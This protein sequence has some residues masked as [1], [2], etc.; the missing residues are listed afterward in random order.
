MSDIKKQLII[1]ATLDSAALKKEVAALKREL[2]MGFSLSSQDT[3]SIKSEFKNIARSFS[4]ELKKAMQ[5]FDPASG[6]SRAAR[7]RTPAFGASEDKTLARQEEREMAKQERLADRSRQKE[8]REKQKISEQSKKFNQ[9]S[10]DHHDRQLAE[11][12]K[13]KMKSVELEKREQEKLAKLKQKEEKTL[14]TIKERDRKKDL[15]QNLKNFETLR[16]RRLAEQVENSRADR[17]FVATAGRSVGMSPE[18]ARGFARGLPGALGAASAGF[19]GGTAAAAG[20]FGVVDKF[21]EA[22]MLSLERR[23]RFAQDIEEGRFLEGEVREK[24]RE[25]SFWDKGTGTAAGAGAGALGG[26]A[27]GAAV[28]SIVPVL[29]TAIGAAIGGLAGAA[30]GGA[31]GFFKGQRLRQEAGEEEVQKAAFGIR[32]FDSAKGLNPRMLQS[33]ATGASV[34]DI[35]G[36]VA[37]GSQF[38]FGAEQSLSQFQETQAALG[39]RAGLVT[40]FQRLQRGFGVG[41]GESATLEETL[42]GLGTSGGAKDGTRVGKIFEKA[43]SAGMDKAKLPALSQALKSTIGAVAGLSRANEE[44]VTSRLIATAQAL[45]RGEVT[46]QTIGQAATLQQQIA[47]EAKSIQGV[48]GGANIMNTMDALK[49]AGIETDLQTA[50]KLSTLAPEQVAEFAPQLLKNATQE[51]L[52]K[53]IP[54]QSAGQT[55]GT[56]GLFEKAFGSREDALFAET[57]TRGGDYAGQTARAT[58][59][60]AAIKGPM[61][62]PTTFQ[63]VQADRTMMTESG[64]LARAEAELDVTKFQA[65]FNLFEEGIRG[66]S[67]GLNKFNEQLEASIKSLQSLI[68]SGASYGV[69][70]T[71][72]GN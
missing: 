22:R 14:S 47:Q 12:V 46:E 59:I 61:L 10:W 38:G 24:G 40:D 28:G 34:E 43:V 4:E 21:R 3:Q 54:A 36:A 63:D 15:D 37:R 58:A 20:T 29:G 1:K 66:A 27:A 52:D 56:L 23:Q 51:Q 2:K 18:G 48:A 71:K 6:T 65:G 8:I 68:E 49:E 30:G 33:I 57:L 42:T 62:E 9:Q 53:F 44:Q 50:I 39:S 32:A 41:V 45:G 26:M 19:A 7:R 72:G 69:T 31:F 35:T 60:D 16:Q 25:T 13:G 5:G 11:S 17:G 70:K 55:K 67:K 64:R